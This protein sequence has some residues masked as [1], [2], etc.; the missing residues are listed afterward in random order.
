T[1]QKFSAN[2]SEMKQL[3]ARDFEDLLQ[4][5]IPVFEGLL[6]EPHNKRVWKQLFLMGH[7]HGLAKLHLHTDAT[8]AI[9]DSV[10]A[11]L[12]HAL[13][14]FEMKTCSMFATRKL[15]KEESTRKRKQATQKKTSQASKGLKEFNMSTYKYH[16]LGDVANTIREYGT[17]ESYS[18]EL[19]STA[20]ES[21]CY[22][23]TSC[24]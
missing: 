4:C 9:L 18:T 23:Y 7:W 14:E 5:A 15:K 8:L 19:V 2:C 22:L 21:L 11:S 24:S 12:G 6:P 17:T 13:H 10:T 20:H 3:A 16:A 1:I